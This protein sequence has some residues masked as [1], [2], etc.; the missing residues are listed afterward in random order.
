MRNRGSLL[1]F[2][3]AA[4]VLWVTAETASAGMR[5]PPRLTDLGRFR[6]EVISFFAAAILALSGVVQVLWNVLRKDFG[7]LPRLTYGKACGVVMLW[8]LLFV[9]VLAMISGARELMTPG[10][11]ESRD[12]GGYRLA[13]VGEPAQLEFARR[14]Q[15]ERLRDALW[16]YA[17]GNGGRFPPH[18]LAPGIADEAWETL[19][20]S[21]LRFLYVP[22][23]SADAGRGVVAYEPGV[24][25]S[26]RLTLTSDG[27]IGFR[28]L[29][30]IR[31]EVDREA[32]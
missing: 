22:G 1:P 25:G 24:Y 28:R 6:L 32:P 7:S 8:G 26:Q 9:V 16:S 21:R 12:D 11:W 15:M 31:A 3:V 27:A 30:E 18:E 29:D 19:H 5:P 20:P 10:A 23:R 13:D 2:A 14:R 4:C 17:K